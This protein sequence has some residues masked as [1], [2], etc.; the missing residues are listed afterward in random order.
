MPRLSTVLLDS[1][2]CEETLKK[3]EENKKNAEDKYKVLENKTKNAGAVREKELKN[4]QQNLDGAKKEADTSSKKMKEKQQ[5]NLTFLP[6]FSMSK[7]VAVIR[8]FDS[9]VLI[10]SFLELNMLPCSQ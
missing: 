5:V 7:V 2:D 3:T 4:A 10:L 8:K 6:I 1:A 9:Q